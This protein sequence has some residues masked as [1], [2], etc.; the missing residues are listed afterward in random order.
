MPRSV[1]AKIDRQPEQPG[2]VP[3]T[4]AAV[5]KAAGLLAY[6]PETSFATGID[7]FCEWLRGLETEHPVTHPGNR[8]V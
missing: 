4:W 6:R 7:R 5:D 8:A 3:Q 1:T 2:D